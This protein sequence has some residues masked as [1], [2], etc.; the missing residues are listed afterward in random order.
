[1]IALPLKKTPAE[2]VLDRMG[3]LRE[4][5]ARWQEGK[6]WSLVY[7]VD[8][9]VTQ[10]LKEAYSLFFS[11]NGLN[12]MVFPSLK[13]FE[14]EVVAM[15][16]ALLGGNNGTVGNMTSGGTES[17]LMAVKTAREWATAKDPA[18]TAP[19]MILPLTAHPAFEKAAYYFSVKPVRIPVGPDYRADVEAAR[20]AITA[21]TILMV[22]SAP[23]YPQGVIDAI[24]ELAQIARE[25]GILFHVDACVGGFMLPFVRKLGYPVPDFDFG[26]PGVTSI[27]VDLHKYAYAAKG[28]SVVLYRNRALRRHQF[29]VYTDWPGGIYAS[30]TMA[31]TRPGGAIAAAWAIMQHLG[32]EGYLAITDSVM[33]TVT[34]LREGIGAI[35]GIHV[36]GDPAMSILSIGS[37]RLNVYEIGDELALRGWHLDRQQF[38]PSLHLT[39]T[40]AH[41]QV[42]D[43]FLY[44][45]KEAVARVQKASLTSLSIALKVG[46]VRAAAKVLPA[47]VMSSLT[48]RSSSVTGLKGAA[49]PK[50]SAA[51]YGMMASLPNR[52]DLNDLVLDVL[53]QMTLAEEP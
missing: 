47:G 2:A 22:G 7:H 43:L 4:H 12:P 28:A 15:T 34:K 46:L 18:N 17:I 38:P 41:S 27:S 1:M 11:E 32:E 23:S 36:L 48:A 3:K 6:T 26:L 5:D 39:V 30:P 25:H 20:S 40:H 9:E 21:N 13:R 42:V 19:E 29:F 14:A 49:I 33:K 37:D 8:D 35:E 51:M 24:A 10:L 53:D 44:D 16:A 50:R 31:G 45:L 52:G